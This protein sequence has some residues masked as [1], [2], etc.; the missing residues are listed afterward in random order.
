M[1]IIALE[2]MKFYAYHGVYE[3]EQRIGADYL[4]DVYVQTVTVP[5]AQTDLLETTI[6]Y[7][8]V[9]QI[10]KMEMGQPRKLLE[11]V[12]NNIFQRM[13]KQFA[14]MMALK[15]R[16][17]K[18][19]PPLGGQVAAAW[20]ED[21]Q[22]FMQNCPRCNKAFI[23][24]NPNDCWERHPNLHPATRETLHRQFGGKCLCDKCLRFYAG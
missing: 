17:R 24:Y 5:A 6:N 16:V 7:E 23:N 20:V 8:S 3:A 18:L 12:V 15:V 14:G 1:A 13:K 2:G 11:T 9:Y 4:V 10:C 19:H 21:D 22:M